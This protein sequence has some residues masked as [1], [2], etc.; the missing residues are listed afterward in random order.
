[1]IDDAVLAVLNH[2][3]AQ[4][5]WARGRLAPFA[6]KHARISMPPWQL[7]LR[8]A[9]D[10]RFAMGA[11]EAA[12]DVDIALPSETPI[13]AVQGLEK[14]LH[15]ARIEGN[16]KFAS[17]LSDVLRNLRWDYEE[18]LS[19][20]VGDIA[21]HRLAGGLAAFAGWQQRVVT[22]F[23]TYAAEGNHPLAKRSD[24]ATLGEEIVALEQAMTRAE[25]RVEALR[26]RQ[27]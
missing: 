7:R 15:Q 27:P 21:A 14:L 6:G 4:A 1:M 26:N 10:G 12:A 11:D 5:D 23:V 25:R 19:R 3:L 17:E 22:G 20:L 8:V 24:V 9:E 16:A 18:D 13:L 2:L